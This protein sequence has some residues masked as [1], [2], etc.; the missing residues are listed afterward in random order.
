MP[1]SVQAHSLQHIGSAG[2]L[3]TR[4]PPVAVPY[5]TATLCS[6]R[7]LYNCAQLPHPVSTATL[8]TPELSSFVSATILS[9]GW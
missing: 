2:P 7:S 9:V 6:L 1:R 4:A 5:H 8:H 3:K